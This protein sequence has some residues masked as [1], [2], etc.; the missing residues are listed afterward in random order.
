MATLSGLGYICSAGE[1]FDSVAL[2]IYGDEK[3]ACDIMD[4]NPEQVGK[5]VFDGSE[6]ILLPAVEKVETDETNNYAAV[7]APWKE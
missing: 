3:Y 1:T 4:A 2:E 5:F 6:K 7:S